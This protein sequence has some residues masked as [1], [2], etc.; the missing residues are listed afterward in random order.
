MR[1]WPWPRR[2]QEEEYEGDWEQHP[3]ELPRDVG[4]T[5]L[6]LVYQ[7]WCGRRWKLCGIKT[8]GAYSKQAHGFVDVHEWDEQLN[9]APISEEEFMNL[10]EE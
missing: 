1:I 7:C 8:D 3:C 9:S 10:L 4:L 2:E 6:G 5:H